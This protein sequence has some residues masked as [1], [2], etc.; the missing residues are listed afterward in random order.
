MVKNE[1]N[2]LKPGFFIACVPEVYLPFNTDFSDYSGNNVY[3]RVDNASL[4]SGAACFD[5]NSAIAIP[6]FANMDYGD[7]FYLHVRY[8]QRDPGNDL[9]TL[10]FNGDCEKRHTFMLGTKSTG[11]YLSL[12]S[13]LNEEKKLWVNSKVKLI[14]ISNV[15]IICVHYKLGSSAVLERVMRLIYSRHSFKQLN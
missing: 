5:G 8:K 9:Q 14:K 3:I 13:N 6:A 10:V 4:T 7:T 11:N 1:C 12:L 2:N 15:K